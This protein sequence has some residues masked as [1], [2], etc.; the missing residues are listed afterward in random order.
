ML[1]CRQN[2]ECWQHHFCNEPGHDLLVRKRNINRHAFVCP[3]VGEGPAHKRNRTS[4]PEVSKSERELP[5]SFRNALLAQ[6]KDERIKM[7]R[8]LIMIWLVLLVVALGVVTSVTRFIEKCRPP[9][10]FSK[11]P[12]RTAP[13]GQATLN[14]RQ[15]QPAHQLR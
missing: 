10:G 12:G 2:C 11:P 7:F 8:Q 15:I 4:V 3:T 14:H 1:R 6:L 5:L 13:T 9:Q